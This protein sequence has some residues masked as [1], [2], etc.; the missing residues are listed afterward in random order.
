MDIWYL[1]LDFSFC[2]GMITEINC[3]INILSTS[4][5]SHWSGCRR[6][7]GEPERQDIAHKNLYFM[8]HREKTNTK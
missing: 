3:S 5:S 8:G 4:W 7:N 2:Q 1:E 6:Y